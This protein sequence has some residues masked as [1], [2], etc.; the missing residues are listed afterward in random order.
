MWLAERFAD[1]DP[2]K[3]IVKMEHLPVAPWDCHAEHN[4]PGTLIT[5]EDGTALREDGNK[6]SSIMIHFWIP[7]DGQGG[8]FTVDN[9]GGGVD[10]CTLPN[11]NNTRE[12]LEIL[13]DLLK[14][15]RDRVD[16]TLNL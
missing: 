13:D 3:E 7:D 14:D 12:L 9:D 5:I 4:G 1:S 15:F 11:I 2:E 8:T 10:V 16:L 6:D